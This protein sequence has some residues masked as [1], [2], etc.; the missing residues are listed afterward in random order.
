MLMNTFYTTRE[1][2]GSIICMK[3]YRQNKILQLYINLDFYL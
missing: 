3:W 1:K 2:E